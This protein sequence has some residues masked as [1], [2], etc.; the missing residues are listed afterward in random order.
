[1]LATARPDLA[2]TQGR[3]ARLEA[4]R[5]KQLA[6]APDEGSDWQATLDRAYEYLASL[7]P[8]LSG[9]HRPGYRAVDYERMTRPLVYFL[10]REKKRDR[11]TAFLEDRLKPDGWYCMG[12]ICSGHTNG[13]ESLCGK[14][15]Y[16]QEYD[17]CPL[18][19]RHLD[20]SSGGRT[21]DFRYEI[22]DGGD[23]DGHAD[24]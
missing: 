18:Q 9:S 8:A 19:V 5:E 11:F 16:H 4:E 2:R 14:C 21:L 10:S 3:V 13:Y 20:V 7:K 12:Q 23:R 22:P 24:S 15:V 1:M 17:E 6:D